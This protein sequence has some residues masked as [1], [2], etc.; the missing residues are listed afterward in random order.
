MTSI[1]L[2]HSESGLWVS[3]TWEASIFFQYRPY[4]LHHWTLKGGRQRDPPWNSEYER[5]ER[6]K[7]EGHLSTGPSSGEDN[8]LP[9]LTR[10]LTRP[11]V[12]MS[13]TAFSKII[14]T[15]AVTFHHLFILNSLLFSKYW[16]I[17]ILK[18]INLFIYY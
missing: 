11:H 18:I 5:K 15:I 3:K 4:T 9:P 13:G 8:H 6:S 7:N 17:Y 1:K 2:K 16:I 14:Y 12:F 10:T